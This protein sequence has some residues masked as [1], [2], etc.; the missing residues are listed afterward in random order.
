MCRRDTPAQDRLHSPT[1]TALCH[2]HQDC[3]GSCDELKLVHCRSSPFIPF[4][5]HCLQFT[6][7]NLTCMDE[8]RLHPRL[9]LHLERSSKP[10]HMLSQDP[11]PRVSRSCKMAMSLAVAFRRKKST[12]IRPE[13]LSDLLFSL[14]SLFLDQA[15]IRTTFQYCEPRL[16]NSIYARPTIAKHVL[17][18]KAG[19]SSLGRASTGRRLNAQ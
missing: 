17:A 18:W 1:C 7:A 12:H 11:L 8:A 16:G 14:Q 13:Q 9:G 3:R 6:N 5:G 15:L 2:H 19:R 4:S 10:N